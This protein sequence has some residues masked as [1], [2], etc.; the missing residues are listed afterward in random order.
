MDIEFMRRLGPRVNIIP[1]IAKS[2][3]LTPE[4]LAGFKARIM[5]DIAHYQIP[6][7]NFPYDAEEDDDETIEQNKKL[8]RL[9]P[10]AVVGGDE[11]INVNGNE[12]RCRRYPWGRVEIDNP[13]HCDVVELENAIW[14]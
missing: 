12:I 10:F 9:L 4:E 3:T 5:E 7:F 2:D 14:V 1:V 8:Q 11:I 6:I 13:A